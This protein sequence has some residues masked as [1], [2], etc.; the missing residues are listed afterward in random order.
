MFNQ[1]HKLA[2]FLLSPAFF[3]LNLDFQLSNKL[4]QLSER[5]IVL[6]WIIKLTTSC[7]PAIQTL[8]FLELD[9][10]SCGLLGPCAALQRDSW[11]SQHCMWT[12]QP[13][14]TTVTPVRQQG[15]SLKELLWKLYL[16]VTETGCSEAT[17]TQ[18]PWL[19]LR[20][21]ASATQ[22]QDT[23][24]DCWESYST[25]NIGIIDL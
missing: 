12:T 21:P 23:L 25:R 6:L 13:S 1:T 14:N 7:R 17:P 5:D 2:F 19:K 11:W 10:R 9:S 16:L 15:W 20:I 8:C 24:P 18:H 3:F 22:P 4:V